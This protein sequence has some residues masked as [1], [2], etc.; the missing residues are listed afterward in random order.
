MGVSAVRIIQ[1]PK[2]PEYELQEINID[3]SRK[4]GVLIRQSKKGAD[5]DSRESRLRQESLVPAAIGLRGDTDSSNVILYDE[6]SGVS[7]TKGYDQRPQLSR[8]YLDIA[9]GVI[10]SI[11]V[12][13][14][15]RLFRDKH[16]RNVS[17]FTEIA[18]QKHIMLIVPGRA[19]YDFTRTRDL[20]AFQR[21]MQEA[22]SYIATHVAYM[23]DMR[24][25]KVQRGGYGGAGLPAPYAIDRMVD[26]DQQVPVIYCPWQPIVVDLFE[27]F[28]DYDY[29][30]T[31]IARYMEEQPYIFPYPSAE[32]LQRY[33]FPTKMRTV[34]G[35]YTFSSAS[36]IRNYFSNL[37]LAGYAKIGK[38]GDGSSVYLA[39]AFEAAVPMELLAESY[40]AIMGH[41]PD[42]TK[43][44]RKKYAMRNRR[45]PAME[46][47]A[48]LH[49]LLQSADGAVSFTMWHRDNIPNY[50]CHRGIAK[51]GWVLNNKVGIMRQQKAW[52]VRC[53][54]LDYLV[55]QRLCELARYDADMSGRIQEIWQQRKTAESDETSLLQTQI[56]KA[57][58]QIRRIDELLTDTEVPLSV[59]ARRRYLKMLQD[60]EADRDR[61]F[62]KQIAQERQ[63]DPAEVIP[64]FY[65]TLSHLPDEHERLAP[66]G[67]KRLARQV[68]RDIR[69]NM[70]SAHLFI[71]QVTWQTGIAI[72]P[73]VALVWRGMSHATVGDWTPE[74]DEIMRRM[75]PVSPQVEIMQALPYRAWNRIKQRA[76]VLRLRRNA[77]QNGPHPINVYPDTM[78][79]DDLETAARLV[80]DPTQQDRLRELVNAL[81]QQ[82]VRGGLSAHWWLPLGAVSYVQN[83]ESNGLPALP[84]LD[85]IT[86]GCTRTS[87]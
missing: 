43:S 6:G 29:M 65:H 60:A 11:V 10:G 45:T 50:V 1:S 56:D 18:E 35:G 68:I 5:L 79:Y 57:E 39:N 28:R 61:L 87:G 24:V 80:D 26:K 85:A 4:T 59:D 69:L 71:L 37:T 76:K 78:R 62:D 40:A 16:F 25:Q 41:Y 70:I 75:Y 20:Q 33:K 42:G 2:A 7:G 58:A 84:K 12:A 73:D 19:I 9:N 21:E 27:R 23:H 36:S 54:E 3:L 66:E 34:V 72:C 22:Y 63:R 82:T 49:G 55:I 32:E 86:A 74:E 15:D 38:D 44:N 48:I 64:N 31:R 17:M 52:E 8:L 14:A 13:R 47:P 81:A 83:A 46:S 30:L 53:E 51:D 67:K 77:P